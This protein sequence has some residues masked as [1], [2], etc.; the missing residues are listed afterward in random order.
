MLLGIHILAGGLAIILGAIALLA[1]KGG[2]IHRRVGLVFVFTMLVLG[3]TAALLGFRKSPTDS[4]VFG[5]L[6]TIYFVVTAM[7]TVRPE[8]PWSRPLNI[9]GSIVAAGL[10]AIDIAW[11]LKAFNSPHRSLNGA[12][13]FM[14]FFLG[15]VMALAAL[16]DFAGPSFRCTW[17]W[18]T[19]GAPPMA[20]VLRAVYRRRIVLLHSSTRGESASGAIHHGA[21]ASS[22]NPAVVWR[23][24]LLVV[25]STQPAPFASARAERFQRNC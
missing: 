8:R 16:G 23:D 22:S 5:S 12:P 18:A 9:A 25:E 14:L 4:N 17:R 24:V 1:R 19:L 15:A 10:A 20:N 11:G 6:M 13:F 3:V 21:D 2:M 7:A